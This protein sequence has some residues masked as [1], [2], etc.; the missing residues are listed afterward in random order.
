MTI[1]LTNEHRSTIA[2]RLLEHRFQKQQDEY[3]QAMVQLAEDVYAD[4]YPQDLLDKLKAL[5]AGAFPMRSEFTVTFG[6]EWCHLEFRERKKGEREERL[7]F[8]EHRNS[9]IKVYEARSPFADRYHK[10]QH[11][12][13]QVR[14]ECRS[15][16]AA[17]MAILSKP[18]TLNKL[19]E[20]WPEV[21]PFT[22]DIG[23]GPA[24]V[25]LAIP[26]PEINKALNLPVIT[27]IDKEESK[28]AKRKC[29]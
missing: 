29:A 8:Y 17:T 27:E 10:I 5:P 21:A 14:E 2:K 28:P 15:A 12:M 13:K 4:L 24:C 26:I 9:A 11:V 18:S 20:I 7:F 23:N 16:K 3:E 1:R 22:A 25:A 6:S 19:V